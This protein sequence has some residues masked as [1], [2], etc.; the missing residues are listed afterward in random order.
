MAAGLPPIVTN[1]GASLDFCPKEG[2]YFIDAKEVSCLEYPCGRMK[3]F[4]YPTFIQPSWAEPDLT[5]L[6]NRM[7]EAFL[8]QQLLKRKAKFV[9]EFARN[10]TW[11]NIM[12]LILKRIFFL[13]D[14][15]INY[16]F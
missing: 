6:G 16:N 12:D 8:D 2:V 5:S 9:Q 15:H 10:Y 13:V 7:R 1:S 3:A 4:Q 11:D 14:R